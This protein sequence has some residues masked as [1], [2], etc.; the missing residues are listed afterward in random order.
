MMNILSFENATA[1]SHDLDEKSFNFNLLM[2]HEYGWLVPGDSFDM[3]TG[4]LL[5]NETMVAAHIF[6]RRWWKFLPFLTSLRDIDDVQNGLLLYKPVEWA[7]NRAKVCIKFNSTGGMSFRLLDEDLHDVVLTTKACSLLP[8]VVDNEIG[9]EGVPYSTFGDLDGQEVHFPVGSSARPSKQLLA[10]H[11]YGAW[12]TVQSLKP[13]IELAMPQLDFS[14]LETQGKALQFLIQQWSMGV[15]EMS[16][17]PQSM[18]VG[19]MLDT[20]VSKSPQP[21]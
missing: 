14:N 21:C 12:L 9:G 15:S 17:T 4:E 19:E 6:Q 7:F 11:A 13:D 20:H 18:G 5:P 8:S 10:L 2:K 16:D 1:A 3:V